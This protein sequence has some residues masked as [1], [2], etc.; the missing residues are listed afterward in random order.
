MQI[1]EQHLLDAGYN[2]FKDYHDF[3]K[4]DTTY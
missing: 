2:K 1:S 4:A 3:K